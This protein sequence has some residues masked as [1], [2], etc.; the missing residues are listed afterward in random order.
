MRQTKDERSPPGSRKKPSR[1][2]NG[3]ARGHD[4]ASDERPTAGR[5]PRRDEGGRKKKGAGPVQRSATR[6]LVQGIKGRPEI[7]NAGPGTGA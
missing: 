2:M 4:N 6:A 7:R 3:D 5:G 1:V